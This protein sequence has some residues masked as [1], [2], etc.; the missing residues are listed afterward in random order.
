MKLISTFQDASRIVIILVLFIFYSCGFG[1]GLKASLLMSSES[2]AGAD[3]MSIGLSFSHPAGPFHHSSMH[4][5]EVKEE[6][7]RSTDLT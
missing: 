7:A 1:L 3:I 2:S 4:A 5:Q 6:T